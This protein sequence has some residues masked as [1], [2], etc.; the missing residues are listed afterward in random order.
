MS[1][2][3]DGPSPDTT[4]PEVLALQTADHLRRLLDLLPRERPRPTR[5][6]ELA[7]AVER[8]LAGDRLNELWSRL[9]PIQ[10]LA[11]SEVLHS[12]DG[13]F[14]PTRFRAKYGDLPGGVA[15]EP[16]RET[17]A[18]L[19]SLFLYAGSS[20][21]GGTAI[22]PA[23][24]KERLYA[25][26]PRSPPL[27]MAAQ[28]ELPEAIAQPRRGYY[29]KQA[30]PVDQVPLTRRDMEHAAQQDLLAVLRLVDRG[31]VAVSAKTRQATAAAVRRIAAVLYGGDF[32]DPAPQKQH[33]W[34]QTVGPIRA[35]AWSLLLQ[36][37]RLAELHG[38]KLALTKAGRT[39]L[40][41]PP[42]ETLELLWDRWLGSTSFDEFRR[43][44]AIKGQ[45]G[46]GARALTAARH[47]RDSIV[48]ALEECPVDRW[49]SCDELA[50]FMQAADLEFSITRNPWT[51]YVGEARYGSLGYAGYH[52][53]S[54]LQG[55]YLLCFLFE[56]AA[57]LGV[58]DVAYTDPRNARL[59]FTRLDATD[60]L[61]FL[62][63]YDGLRYFRLTALGAWCLGRTES[64]Q[65]R[66]PA[67]RASITVFPDLRLQVQGA[68]LTQDEALLL[69]TYARQEAEDVWRLDRDKTL[70]VLESGG[71]V[72][73]LREFLTTRDEQP[74]PE[75]VEGFLDTTARRSQALVA[76]GAALLI[77]CA[78]AALAE[79]LA[80][81][82]RTA[83]LCRR[84]G[85]R[86]LV[87]RTEAEGRF[88]K[89]IRELGY[90][91]PRR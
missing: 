23:D 78:D 68:D 26:V 75:T 76:Q 8:R 21:G 11:V 61:D 45:R 5:K 82:E 43:I 44:E 46:R 53:W 89:A 41:K 77:E 30:P 52:D 50:R 91:M 10:R 71:R 55:R 80:T 34:E 6:A 63:R 3:Y 15:T 83:K 84:T 14:H 58:V 48:E 2:M 17:G 85:E 1:R 4:L 79:Q 19:L 42:A 60:E 9:T 73:E 40:G 25:F 64:Y 90:G 24:L 72:D 22:I 66:P 27:T 69:E 28:D 87:V 51:L 57:T 67:A 13:A 32:F 47:R 35:F 39:A 37:A 31:S 20:F 16:G 18:S 49:V 33:S 86:G 54:I 38:S 36:A 62:S 65:P 74:L 59:D 29:G 70:T 88:R 56:Y 7:A 81:H 12:S